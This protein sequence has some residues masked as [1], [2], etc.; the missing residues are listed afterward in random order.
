MTY[1][2]FSTFCFRKCSIGDPSKRKFLVSAGFQFDY[3]FDW[4]ILK[5]Q[6]NQMTIPPRAMVGTIH[7]ALFLHSST[8]IVEYLMNMI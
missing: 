2:Y 4:T 6:Q 3:I 1:Y 7:C 5:Y 8:I